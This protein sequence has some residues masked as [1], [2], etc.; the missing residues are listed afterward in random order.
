MMLEDDL[1]AIGTCS[2]IVRSLYTA[3]GYENQRRFYVFHLYV[4]Q[5]S[6]DYKVL[7]DDDGFENIISKSTIEKIG[8]K[9]KTHLQ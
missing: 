4:I 6:Q 9:T 2:R 7:I 3:C 8:L 5:N 1:R